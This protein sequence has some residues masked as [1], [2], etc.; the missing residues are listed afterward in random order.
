MISLTDRKNAFAFGLENAVEKLKNK[1]NLFL[2]FDIPEL[3]FYPRD[4]FRGIENCSITRESAEIRQKEL[5]E[6]LQSI[7]IKFPNITIFNPFDFICD[8]KQKI[9]HCKCINRNNK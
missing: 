1:K 3:P 8:K 4:C 2:F 7:K 5:W 6:I 9:G